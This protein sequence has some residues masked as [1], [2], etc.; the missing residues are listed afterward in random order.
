MADNPVDWLQ[1]HINKGVHLREIAWVLRTEKAGEA[2]RCD[3]E[4]WRVALR[5]GIAARIPRDAHRID[6]ANKF[7]PLD[8]PTWHVWYDPKAVGIAVTSTGTGRPGNDPM[9]RHDAFIERA[10]EIVREWREAI[11]STPKLAKVGISESDFRKWFDERAAADAKT[12]TR[13]SREATRAAAIRHFRCN[14]PVDWVKESH[15]TLS[16]D[17]PWRHRG[18]PRAK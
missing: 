2:W 1:V 5:D 18:R 17:H 10:E 8:L 16:K 14:I 3:A 9:S 11:P 6:A 13:S 7:P 12:D 15:K 4:A